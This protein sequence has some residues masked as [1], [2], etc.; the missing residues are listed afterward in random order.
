MNDYFEKVGDHIKEIASAIEEAAINI[1]IVAGDQGH[2]S[3]K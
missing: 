2:N 1:K 3:Q